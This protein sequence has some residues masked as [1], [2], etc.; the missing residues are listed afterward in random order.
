MEPKYWKGLEERAGGE[1]FRARA[2]TEFPENPL[3]EIES[4]ESRRGFLKA[5]G[6]TFAGAFLAGCGRAPVTKALPYLQEPENIVPGRSYY[7]ASTCCGCSAG[8]GLLVKTR[9]GRPIKLEGNSQ[10]ALSRGATCAVGQASIL[11]LYDSLRLKQPLIQGK[12]AAWNEVDSAITAQLAKG[13]A[14]RYLSDTITSPTKLALIEHFLK[15]FQD[16]R[17]VTYDPLSVSAILDAHERTHGVRALPHFGF[18]K[19]EVIVGFDAD[20]LGTWISPVEFTRDY[21]QNRRPPK[22][23]YHVQ[24]EPRMSITGSKADR[25]VRVA[26]EEIHQRLAALALR[27]AGT[28]KPAPDAA[29]DVLAERL[30]QARG[31]SLV[32]CGTQSVETQVLANYVNHLLGNYGATLDIEH[33]SRQRQGNDGELEKLLREIEQGKVATLFIDG[34]NPMADLPIPPELERIP[35]VVSF[36]QRLDETASAARYVCPDHHY[37]ESWG[38][39]EA[40]SGMLSMA[41]PAIR[42]LG[43]SR[44]VIESLAHWTGAPKPAHALVREHWQ[45]AIFPRQRQEASFQ[46]FWER[47]VELGYARVDPILERPQPFNASAAREALQTKPAAVSGYSVVLYATTGMLDGREAYNPWLQEMPD[48]ITKGTWDNYAC[49][50]PATAARLKIQDGDVVRIDAGA[51]LELPVVI[52]PGQ[53]DRVIAVALG[54]GRKVSER[55]ANIGPHWIDRLNT[56]GTDGRVGRNASPFLGLEGG[57]LRYVRSGAKLTPTGKKQIVALTQIHHTLTAP[58][59]LA[60]AGTEPRPIVQEMRLAE[61]GPPPE[62]GHPEE[63]LWPPDHP[64]N[65]H[66]WGMA[67][68]LN[69]CTGCSACVVACQVENNIPVVG[70][71]EVR[72]KREMHW[73][74][75]DR[76]YSGPPDEVD[77][78]YQPM[79][80][81]HCENAPCETVCPVLATVHSDEGLNQQIYNRCVGTRYCENNCP[82]KTRRFNWFNYPRED[83]LANLVLNPDV[84]VRTRGVMEKCSFCVQRI[85]EAKIEARRLG[86]PVADGEIQTACQQACPAQAIVFGDMNAPRSKV[87]QM[88]RSRRRYRVLEEINVQPSVNYLKL[89]RN[90]EEEGG[91]HNG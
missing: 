51:A 31:R 59:N 75:I 28:G 30:S 40:V 11:G 66:R 9:D 26:P 82:Y 68:D 90:R 3:R 23:S 53:H 73:I 37:L 7:Y 33:P 1:A 13:G 34:V 29:L 61:F 85:Q 41:Q 79:L 84:T 52:Q 45:S 15:Q 70:K 14:V 36:A 58:A 38:D 76:Y 60:A 43:G 12:P 91:N 18:G 47:S 27:L 71:D 74:R 54:Y 21:V 16:V 20:F 64:Y 5:A 22:L 49:L 83:R 72:R 88:I 81:Q 62:P 55:F 56:V 17:H 2:E 80:C 69:A 57:T 24:F 65:G 46:A 4:G 19:A 48:P 50:S 87:N 86:R 35:L 6:F 42:P 77:V 78:A 44:A 25:R 32:V 63:Q 10:H 67:I 39:A 8:C 89:V